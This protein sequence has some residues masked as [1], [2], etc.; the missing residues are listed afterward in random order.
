MRRLLLLL[1][2]MVARPALAVEP[3]EM[4]ADPALEARARDIS[5]G[6]R[7]VVCRNQSIDDSNAGIAHDMR[8]LLRER[9]V[10]GDS[11][12]QAV[13]FIVNRYGDFV[14]LKPP[15]TPATWLLW[16]GPGALLIITGLAFVRI[17]RRK[18]SIGKEP[19]TQEEREQV[20]DLLARMEAK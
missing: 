20:S 15:V 10:A 14:L 4:L 12:A 5:Q 6:L 19:L 1:A 11:D 9:L 8:V 17:A 18:G 7:C 16:G 2:L 3:S 13:A